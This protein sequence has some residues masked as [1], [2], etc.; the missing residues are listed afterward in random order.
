MEMKFLEVLLSDKTTLERDQHLIII[1]IIDRTWYVYD[2]NGN[3]GY[4][5]NTGINLLS[6][7]ETLS[8]LYDY[9]IAPYFRHPSLNNKGL[10]LIEN[11]YGYC[12]SWSLL[13]IELD[14]TEE[15]IRNLFKFNEYERKLL[16]HGYL[17]NRKIS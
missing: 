11:D 1:K 4:L 8:G 16:M 9:E 15:V 10:E 6:L 3:A 7:L 2:P 17:T 12:A 5:D 14:V 13:F